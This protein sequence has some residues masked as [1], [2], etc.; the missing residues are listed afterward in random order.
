MN[1]VGVKN[2]RNLSSGSRRYKDGEFYRIPLKCFVERVNFYMIEYLPD[3]F[4]T[5]AGYLISSDDQVFQ[6]TTRDTDEIKDLST[7]RYLLE[8]KKLKSSKP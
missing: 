2:R 8:S 1:S 3:D 7:R 6:N 5:T 4:V